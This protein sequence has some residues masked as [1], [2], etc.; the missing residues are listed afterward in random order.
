M[1]SG[2]DK[3][4]LTRADAFGQSNA[5]K[6]RL[7]LDQRD[8]A[9]FGLPPRKPP[10]KALDPRAGNWQVV[11]QDLARTCVTSLTIAR[12]NGDSR[13]AVG[14]L[15]RPNGEIVVLSP[16]LLGQRRGR[17]DPSDANA[18]DPIRFREATGDD[19]A[20]AHAPEARR[21]GPCDLRTEIYLVG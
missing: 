18:G 21:S 15:V 14:H 19:N 3:R 4:A 16:A 17:D 1:R 20:I 2:H 7:V 9:R 5:G 8:R 11:G 10:A 13:D 6:R 12:V